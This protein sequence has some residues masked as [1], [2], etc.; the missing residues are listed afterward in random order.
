[1]GNSPCARLAE[2]LI[3]RIRPGPGMKPEII[4]Y[5]L[6]ASSRPLIRKVLESLKKATPGLIRYLSIQHALAHLE[7]HPIVLR[8]PVGFNAGNARALLQR[9]LQGK[10]RRR[11]IYVMLEL[12]IL[13]LAAVA[14]ILPGPN[15]AFYLLFILFYFHLK[16]LLHLRKI[17]ME[18][19]TI[20]IEESADYGCGTDGADCRPDP[21]MQK[22]G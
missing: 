5:P 16:A 17:K 20:T 6:L 14:A 7:N 8:T 15:V 22:N 18:K 4:L 2:P 3:I 13:P 11:L 9:W 10:V 1:M 12:L 19:L 21:R